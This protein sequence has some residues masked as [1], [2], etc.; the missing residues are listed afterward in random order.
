MGLK[1]CGNCA[2]LQNFYTR[3]L[4]EITVFDATITAQKMKFSIKD[5]IGKYEQIQETSD[6]VLIT[7]KSLMENF[8]IFRSELMLNR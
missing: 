4:G 1:L 2:F 7:E 6:L 5:F 8:I 3:K